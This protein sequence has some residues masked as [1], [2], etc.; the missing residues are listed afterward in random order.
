MRQ[1][2]PDTENR[3][4]CRNCTK[5]EILLNNFQKKLKVMLMS[6]TS[7]KRE[8]SAGEPVPHSPFA[9]KRKAPEGLFFGLSG[10]RPW[11]DSNPRP[12]A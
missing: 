2:N 8:K 3:P 4:K 10:E 5:T 11:R 12:F 6:E 7:D 1:T 9:A